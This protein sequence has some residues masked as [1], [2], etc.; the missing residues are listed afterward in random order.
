MVISAVPTYFFSTETM[1][2]Q[3]LTHYRQLFLLLAFLSL[4]LPEVSSSESSESLLNP[5]EDYSDPYA[6]I[7][8]DSPGLTSPDSIPEPCY[9]DLCQDLPAP[10]AELAA[11]LRCSCPG[12]SMGPSAH[13]EAPV[14]KIYWREGTEPE[15]RW[16]AAHADENVYRVLVQGKEVGE[17]GEL[18]RSTVVKGL[19]AGAEVCVQAVNDVGQSALEGRACEVYKPPKGSPSLALKV[20]LIGGA[21]GLLLLISLAALLWRHRSRR[22]DGA[23]VSTEGPL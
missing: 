21:L 17:F 4:V 12:V 6:R 1:Q 22:K 7:S 2:T 10:C 11:M 18:K 20:G 19:S 3:G 13:P 5:S 15:V 8:T 14:V 16:C 9:K 23:R